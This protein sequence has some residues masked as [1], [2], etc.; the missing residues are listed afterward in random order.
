MKAKYTTT[1]K[2][3]V[4]GAVY[5]A[6]MGATVPTDATTPLS[7]DYKEMGYCDDSGITNSQETETYEIK[8]FGG[9]TVDSGI[10]SKTVSLKLK[11]IEALNVETLKAVYGS[12]NVTG[13]LESGI[14]VKINSKE[15]EE[16]VWV[17]ELILRD[18][19]IKRIVAPD[20]KLSEIG[21]VVYKDDE[22]VGYEITLKALPDENGDAQHEYMKK[23]DSDESDS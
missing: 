4:G 12:D 13:D 23:V 7:E 14:H 19:T 17:V 10:K 8:A 1:A 20:V 18:G 2:P 16:S 11:L 21:D 5:R 9:D 22:S 15:V 3:Q 6:P